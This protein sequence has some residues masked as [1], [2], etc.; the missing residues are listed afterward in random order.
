[1]ASVKVTA[2]PSVIRLALTASEPSTANEFSTATDTV[3]T[4][5]THPQ[6]RAVIPGSWTCFIESYVTGPF[7]PTQK[8]AVLPMLAVSYHVHGLRL[9]GFAPAGSQQISVDV[10]HIALARAAPI[11]SVKV[12]VSWDRG[13]TWQPVK[14]SRTSAGHYRL[15]FTAPAGVDPTLSL[16]ATDAA[17]NS[18]AETITDAYGVGG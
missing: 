3:W 18:I 10:G 11:V 17:G 13:R 16:T 6:P 14:V 8:C 5:H 2:K 7:V 4:M 9:D 15:A 1:M 12:R